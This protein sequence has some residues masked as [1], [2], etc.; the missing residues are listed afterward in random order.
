MR[1]SPEEYFKEQDFSMPES[2]KENFTPAE[3]AFMAKYMGVDSSRVLEQLGIEAGDAQA[4]AAPPPPELMIE[5]AEPAKDGSEARETALAVEGAAEHT[6]QP[7]P[8]CEPEAEDAPTAQEAASEG[9][10]TPQ[11]I[12]ESLSDAPPALEEE[13]R[14]APA[15]TGENAPEAELTEAADVLPQAEGMEPADIERAEETQAKE[16][17]AQLPERENAEASQA[18]PGFAPAQDLF[19]AAEGFELP[20]AYLEETLK[21]EPEIQMVGFFIGGQEFTIPT[22][23]VQ[24]VIRYMPVAKLP[25]APSFVAG[26]INLRG[27]VTPL[28][29]LRDI[30]EVRSPRR[31]ENR[32][33]II[34]RRQ[35]LQVGMLIEKVHTMYRVPQADIEWGIE[36][37]LGVNADCVAG[38]FKQN[39]QLV[40][41]VSV[42]RV[43]AGV[44]K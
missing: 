12:Q 7:A 14:Q 40:S 23:A 34:C 28:V 21:L 42:D 36:A 20:E 9:A 18:A 10:E 6:L 15:A 39:E 16:P 3:Q 27:R 24:E 37:H 29:E 35:G 26:V 4:A 41:I 11:D 22:A 19:G 33:I 5:A 38:L 25:A 30:L 17:A 44:L 13:S 31:E 1:K 2:G 8:E 32:F 43:I